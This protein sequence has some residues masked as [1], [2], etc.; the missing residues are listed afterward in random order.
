MRAFSILVVISTFTAAAVAAPVWKPGSERAAVQS[1]GENDGRVEIRVHPRF[2]PRDVTAILTRELPRAQLLV[3]GLTIIVEGATTREIQRAL[4]PAEVDPSLDD[5]DALL[6]DIREPGGPDEGSGSSVRARREADLEREVDETDSALP[7][8]W[9]RVTGV[10]R[11]RFPLVLVSV[12][13]EAAPPG[14]P[15]EAGERIVIL[16]RVRSRRGIIDPDDARS[17]QNMGAWYVRKGDPVRFRL[18]PR[19]EDQKIWVAS[20]FERIERR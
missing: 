9:G 3:D 16:P 12:E 7:L 18:E 5:I 13:L 15:L 1:I 8:G 2:D 4:K 19:P 17:L 11:Q 6:A 10:Q 14:T 20:T